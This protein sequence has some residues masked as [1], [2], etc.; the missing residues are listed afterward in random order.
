MLEIKIL[1]SPDSPITHELTEEKITV[2]RLADNTLHIEDDSVS[3]R[4]AELIQKGEAYLLR[5]LGST[6]GT[7]VN[8][9]QIHETL[10]VSGDMIRFGKIDAMYGTDTAGKGDQPL[11]DATEVR[12]EAGASSVR[13]VDFANSSPFPKEVKKGDPVAALA[14]AL[15]ILGGLAFA[16]SIFATF[17]LM[18][19][20]VF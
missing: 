14:I 1:L 15:A 17:V 19:A 13:P 9:S 7:F 2:G 4:H 20:P 10:L 12:G 16:G 11:P 3:S 8:G 18:Q 6:N 5:D